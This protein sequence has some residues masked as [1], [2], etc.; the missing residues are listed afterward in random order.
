MVEIILHPPA[1]FSR[2]HIWDYLKRST[3]ECLFHVDEESI[4]RL[5]PTAEGLQLIRITA[6][7]DN[8]GL[9]ISFPALEKEPTEALQAEAHRYVWDWL[10]CDRDLAPFFDLSEQDNV[11]RDAAKRFYGLR[12]VGIDD[13]FEAL[14]WGIMG[15]QINLTFAYTLKRRFVERFG[16]SLEW[17]GRRY[18]A[19]PSP[20]TIAAIEPAELTAMQFTGRKAEY[21]IGTAAELAEGRLSKEQLLALPDLPAIEKALTRIRGIG[22]WTANYV[23]MRCLRMPGAFPIEDV[24]LHNALKHVLQREDKPS[25][26]EIKGLSAGWGEWRSYATFYLWRLL[27]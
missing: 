9:A 22:P 13:L 5:I 11:L 4:E 14:S 24:G 18:Y 26:A 21:L 25:I 17:N 27:Y 7:A 1:A 8:D 3:N 10:D 20:E 23:I 12:I 15:Q 6:A 16:T 19:F 2:S